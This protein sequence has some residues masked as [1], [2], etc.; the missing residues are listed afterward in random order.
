MDWNIHSILIF[1]K[2]YGNNTEKLR[3]ESAKSLLSD[4]FK[5]LHGFFQKFRY[6]SF[7]N[8]TSI[9]SVLTLTKVKIL[10]TI[11]FYERSS[12]IFLMNIEYQILIDFLKYISSWWPDLMC[13]ITY[14][15]VRTPLLLNSVTL[16]LRNS[17]TPQL[18]KSEKNFRSFCV[19]S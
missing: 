5:F 8:L 7:W 13:A 4:R 15:E 3:L 16:Q 18:R 17:L 2:I 9:W 19:R 10:S 6:L 1:C 11:I 14:V 12:H